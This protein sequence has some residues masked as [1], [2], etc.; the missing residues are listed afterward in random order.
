MKRSA[1]F[2]SPRGDPVLEAMSRLVWLQ[3]RAIRLE[4]KLERLRSQEGSVFRAFRRLCDAGGALAIVAGRCGRQ[5]PSPA[6]DA[7]VGG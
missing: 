5:A 2:A 4:R 6:G 3:R 7:D 1:E